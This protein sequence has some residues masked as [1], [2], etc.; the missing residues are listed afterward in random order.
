[1]RI[2]FWG[3]Y[4][5]GKPRVR[6][7]LRGLREN[8]VEVIECHKEVWSGIEDKSQIKGF[9][10]KLRLL[11][12]WLSAYPSLIWR[13]LRLPKHDAVVIGYLGQLDVLVLWPFARLRGVPIV[14]D[15]FLSLYN[16]VVEDRQ[17]VRSNSPLAWAL[18]GW[19][20]LACKAA[21]ILVLDTNEHGRYFIETFGVPAEKVK[22]VFVGAE[23]DI[24]KPSYDIQLDASQPFTVLFYGQFIPL[25]GVDTIVRAA[26]LTETEGIRWVI[27]GT[28]QELPR[29]LTLIDELKPINLEI[30]E[31]IPYKELVNWLY[32]SEVCLGIFGATEKASRVIPN[33]VFQIIAADRPLIT[34][35]TPAIRELVKSSASITLIPPNDAK[36]L[37]LAVLNKRHS[38]ATAN[39]L[40][41]IH[42]PDLRSKIEP[43]SV[44]TDL[45]N[46]LSIVCSHTRT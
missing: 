46:A 33:K 3:T 20:W 18:W 34:I 12:I 44:A 32:K 6:I 38:S 22:R 4:D 13:F 31:W 19:E 30:I 40:S 25:H 8:G 2:V 42:A 1:M 26:K 37:A 10:R 36:A 11:F 14:W 15:A 35:E 28:G 17:M 5:T 21:D 43:K 39:E 7:L 41:A 9:A 45:L 27:V 23:T 29:I 24:F 16:T